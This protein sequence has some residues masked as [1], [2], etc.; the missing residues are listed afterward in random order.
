MIRNIS[1]R[2]WIIFSIVLCV[3]ILIVLF[4]YAGAAYLIKSST[5]VPNNSIGL[6]LQGSSTG[7]REIETLA[8]FK[9]KKISKIVFVD[10]TPSAEIIPKSLNVNE[11][12]FTIPFQENMRRLGISDSLLI[13]IPG[14]A[15]STR[16]EAKFALTQ[17]CKDTSIKNLTIIT[18]SYHTRR[19][20][21]IFKK[22]LSCLN[23]NIKIYMAHNP[24]TPFKSKGWWRDRETSKI[25]LMEWIK[26]LHFWCWERWRE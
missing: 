22:E 9:S 16:D 21:W 20:Y 4:F 23:C 1:R 17:L 18:S 6:T 11:F 19:A 14:P 8:L 5:N 15:H 2:R 24:Y 25:V 13:L 12:S 26:I 10:N 3:F 7:E